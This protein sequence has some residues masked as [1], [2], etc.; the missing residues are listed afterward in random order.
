MHSKLAFRSPR[1]TR[2]A[3]LLA[4]LLPAI[5]LGQAATLPVALQLTV[6][7]REIRVGESVTLTVT[8]K[9]TSGATVPARVPTTVTVT[10]SLLPRP[11]TLRLAAGQASLAQQL[12]F[13]SPGVASFQATSPNMIPGNAMVVVTRRTSRNLLPGPH[14]LTAVG[15]DLA[16][17]RPTEL[18][19]RTMSAVVLSREQHARLLQARTGGA[20]LAQVPA[21]SPTANA[22][23]RIRLDVQPPQVHPEQGS[24]KT[25]IHVTTVNAAGVP[26]PTPEDVQVQFSAS[27]GTPTPEQVTIPAGASTNHTEVRLT[28]RAPGHATVQAWTTR[29]TVEQTVEYENAIPKKIFVMT[30]PDPV[31]N[32]GKSLV[33]IT[34]L[35]LDEEGHPAS[36]SDREAQ[37]MLR[38][39]RGDL[40]PPNPLKI[41]QRL[42]AA[43]ATL[44][45]PTAGPVTISA[46]LENMQSEPASVL[47][48]FPWLLVF[49][50]AA[51][52]LLGAVTRDTTTAG[53]RFRRLAVNLIPGVILGLV[54]YTLTLF[55]AIGSI[56]KTVVPINTTVI[57][58]LNELGALLLGILGGYFGARFLQPAV[59]H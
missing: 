15:L 21:V 27:L 45:C 29:G 55:G 44:T 22:V 43:D 56:P 7:A 38:T 5:V 42:P 37:V 20:L 23:A 8:L 39:T 31:Q 17:Q 40:Q 9:S 12:R 48:V 16:A 54:F 58:T 30:P 34:V 53:F 11:I 6:S 36:Y 50:A 35:L 32:S 25:S 51:G 4:G 41:P 3:A 52:G 46:I 24:W 28:A 47:F 1:K 19:V 13:P 2:L 59:T 33:R 18:G 10:G 26:V 49:L 57:P 14:L